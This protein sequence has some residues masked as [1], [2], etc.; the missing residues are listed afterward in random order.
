AS[1]TYDLANRREPDAARVP[2]PRPGAHQIERRTAGAGEVARRGDELA[3]PDLRDRGRQLR[4][5]LGQICTRERRG[6]ELVRPLEKLVDDLDVVGS[7][8]EARE[9]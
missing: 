4:L 1:R 2:Q 5:E 6:D 9:G 3:A 8:A 7:G